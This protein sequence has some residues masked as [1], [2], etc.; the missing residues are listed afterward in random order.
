MDYKVPVI[1]MSDV[2]I[3]TGS[4]SLSFDISIIDDT[5]QEGNETFKIAIQLLPS[6]VPLM[7]GSP[8]S[9]IVTII[10]NDGMTYFIALL[11][12]LLSYSGNDRIYIIKF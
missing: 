11:L 2:I 10:D 8:S 4:K 1:L 9:S 7:L 6:C 3:P 5:V 12:L